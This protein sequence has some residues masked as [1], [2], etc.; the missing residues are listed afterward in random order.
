MY[1]KF[2]YFILLVYGEEIYYY[3]YFLIVLEFKL[4]LLLN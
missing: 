2:D 3:M 1:G 4:K